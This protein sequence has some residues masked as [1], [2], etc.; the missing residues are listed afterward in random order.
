MKKIY[1]III[2]IVLVIAAILITL[3]LNEDSWIKDEQGNWIKH[4]NPSSQAPTSSGQKQSE[5]SNNGL[6]FI[7]GETSV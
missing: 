6:D 3:R 7:E 1:W 5:N 4:G 2:G